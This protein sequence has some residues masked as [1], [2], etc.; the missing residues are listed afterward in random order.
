[1]SPWFLL[2]L[3]FLATFSVVLINYNKWAVSINEYFVLYVTSALLAFGGGCL[4]V[5]AL[6]RPCKA[7]NNVNA[8]ELRK[9][10]IIKT[11]Y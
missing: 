10:F 1:M 4:V 2:C 3:M 8:T 7:P 6:K 5:Q 11:K 9:S